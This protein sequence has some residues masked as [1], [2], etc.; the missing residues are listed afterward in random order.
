MPL[1]RHTTRKSKKFWNAVFKASDNRPSR[2]I[3]SW[4]RMGSRK[5]G[6]IANVRH[7]RLGRPHNDAGNTPRG[8]GALLAVAEGYEG[9]GLLDAD[10]WYDEKHIEKCCKAADAIH[11]PPAD[12]VFAKRRI[13]LPGGEAVEVLEEPNPMQ[14]SVSI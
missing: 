9:I 14:S 5:T 12:V 13:F 1:S 3:I 2:Q 6:W 4:C 8:L 11:T 7:I 10:N